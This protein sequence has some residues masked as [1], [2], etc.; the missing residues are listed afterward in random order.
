MNMEN[1]PDVLLMLEEEGNKAAAK[2]TAQIQG[3]IEKNVALINRKAKEIG[4]AEI[5]VMNAFSAK[6]SS[7]NRDSVSFESYLRDIMEGDL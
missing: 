3:G 6:V 7:F 5:A 2:K 4:E 1:R